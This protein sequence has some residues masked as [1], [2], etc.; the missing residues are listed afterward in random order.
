MLLA[1]LWIIVR[2]GWPKDMPFWVQWPALA[3]FVGSAIGLSVWLF[4]IPMTEASV[5]RDRVLRLK[6]RWPLRSS[7][8]RIRPELVT[9]VQMIEDTDSDGD[10][11]FRCRLWLKDGTHADLNEGW[12]RERITGDVARIREALGLG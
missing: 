4:G 5:G 11:Y 3:V 9:S 10:P 7:E 12:H 6:R 2:D 1:F 8:A